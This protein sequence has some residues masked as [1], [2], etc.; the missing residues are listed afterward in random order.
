MTRIVSR[1]RLLVAGL[2]VSGL[3]VAGCGGSSSNKSSS[4]DSS[5][6]KA[7]QLAAA[8]LAGSGSTFQQPFNELAIQEFQKGQP[9]VTV[10]YGGG[11]S[12]KGQTD[13]KGNLVQWAGS[14]TPIKPA[15]AA[16]YKPVFY[17]P[18][19]AAPITVSYNL[20]GVGKLQLSADTLS[21]IFQ[22]QIV[23][24]DDPA[25][26]AEN[27]GVSLPSTAI[28]VVHRSDSSGTTANFSDF[29]Q[30]A[31]PS[32]WKLGSDKTIDWPAGTQSGNGNP[33]VAQVIKSTN[34]AVG[35]VDFSDAKQ[36]GLSFA[37]I[38]NS[39]GS[40]VAPSLD[41]AS[42]ALAS[43]TVNTNLTYD[44]INAP[45]ADAYP[46]TSPTYV[47]V[48]QSQTGAVGNALK[49]WLDFLL[50]PG[51]DLAQQVDFTKL[52]QSILSKAQAQV[53]QIKVS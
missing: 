50:G 25:I 6:S 40:F 1:S 12:G 21:K 38:K 26:K 17:F 4:S 30:K 2:A 34:G 43:A 46:I 23:K 49:G 20:S 18:T 35:Y 33:G 10:T 11:G 51:Q 16:G 45:G 32:T 3:I 53:Q 5:T 48:Y 28:T 52:P 29:L 9:K 27:S 37:S 39:A 41:S 15:D 19:V 47:I 22:R 24:W 44:P 36:A 14:D 31:A 13:L 42:A 7:P 8:T